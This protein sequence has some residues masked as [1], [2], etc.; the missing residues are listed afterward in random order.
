MNIRNL[1]MVIISTK[2]YIDKSDINDEMTMGGDLF[3]DSLGFMAIIVEIEKRISLRLPINEL[4][5]SPKGTVGEFCD[6]IEEYYGLMSG[7]NKGHKE[8]AL[9]F[10]P[11]MYFSLHVAVAMSIVLANNE[12]RDWFYSNFI[13]VTFCNGHVNMKS[14]HRYGI[15]PALETRTG[16][17]A[18]SKFLTEKHIDLSV[19]KLKADT[20]CENIKI[21]IDNGYYVSC[22]ADVSKIRGTRYVKYDFFPHG[23]MIYG[24]DYKSKTFDILDFD[25]KERISR[26]KVSMEDIVS[27]FESVKL[28]DLFG[29]DMNNS[30]ILYERKNVPFAVDYTL[31]KESLQDYL[32]SYNSSKR[33]SLILPASEKLAWGIST[34]EG[35]KNYLNEFPQKIDNRLFH[36]FYEHKK[37]MLERFEYF[38]AKGICHIETELVKGLKTNV[39]AAE[40][41][42]ML[43]MKYNYTMNI[44]IIEKIIHKLNEIEMSE[45]YLYEKILS[46][47]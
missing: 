8:L 3:I 27:A 14:G 1:I 34:Y 22:L 28:L 13:Q 47:G 12:N 42:K 6:R 18:A 10:P 23:L 40:V 4:R 9:C 36:A 15:Y 25:N 31:V 45:K 33:Y 38:N 44:D 20:L 43:A 19:V 46:I 5:L 30:L 39:Q 29:S 37:I 11:P 26:I 35:I 16:Q 7:E 21:F 17:Y 24:Y 2:C 32:N 41:V